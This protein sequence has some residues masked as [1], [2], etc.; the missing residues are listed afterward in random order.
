[1]AIRVHCCGRL[2]YSLP[3]LARLRLLPTT[4]RGCER[5]SP[6]H[7]GKNRPLPR[8]SRRNT[9]GVHVRTGQADPPSGIGDG[10]SKAVVLRRQPRSG[11]LVGHD[12]RVE[13]I[14]STSYAVYC[15][16]RLKLGARLSDKQVAAGLCV[17]RTVTL[18]ISRR[19]PHAL[20]AP[21]LLP[22]STALF[23]SPRAPCVTD[24]FTGRRSHRAPRS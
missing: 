2:V 9:L 1:M 20:G 5:E 17:I 15:R 16:I 11:A 10:E 21:R 3:F 19:R 4:F 6:L 13:A 7:E 18:I 24:W 23:A 12:I 14:C 8:L 22:R